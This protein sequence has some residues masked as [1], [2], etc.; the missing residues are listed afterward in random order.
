MVKLCII[1]LLI[2]STLLPVVKAQVVINEIQSSN[3]SG[4]VDEDNEHSDWIELYNSSDTAENIE[5]YILN[6]KRT[7]SSGWV[8]PPVNILPN[9]YLLVFASGKDRNVVTPKY[10]TIIKRGDTWKYFVATSG[11]PKNWRDPDFNDSLWVSGPSGF[12]FGDNDDST[13]INNAQTVL[14]RKEFEIEDTSSISEML[15]H[16]DYDDG[17]IA[18]INGIEVAMGN[19]TSFNKDFSVVQTGSREALMCSGGDPE[20]FTISSLISTLRNGRNVIAIQGHNSSAN[21]SDFSLI[22]FLTLGSTDYTANDAEHFVNIRNGYLHTNFKIS[23]DGEA[24]YLFNASSERIDSTKSIALGDDISYGRFIDGD[25]AWYYFEQPTPGS[26]N[27]NP[28][29][30]IIRDS[31]FF[32]EKAGFYSQPFGLVMYATSDSG[33]IYFTTDGSVPT[34]ESQIYTD[35][36]TISATTVIRAAFF[37]DSLSKN[38]VTTETFIFNTSNG[39]PVVSISSDPKNFFDWN[40]GILVM[41]PNA[42][43]ANPN[44][45]ANFWMDW[46]K[47]IN[48]EYFDKDGVPHI[49]QGAGIKVSGMWSR[50]NAQKSVAIFARKEYGKGAFK[51]K[52]F[53]DRVN[54]TFES[55]TLRNSG[56]DWSYTMMRDGLFSEMAKDMDIDREAYQPSVVYLNGEYWGI[57]N[58]RERASEHY[59]SENFGVDDKEVNILEN[60]GNVVYGKNEDYV[61]LRSFINTKS[62]LSTENY[63]QVIEKMD[64][65]CF[66]DYELFQIYIDNGDWPGN[67]IKYWKSNDLISKWR[68]ILY[69]ADFGF[70]IYGGPYERNTLIFATTDNHNE[71]PN[72]PWS[73]LFLRKLL[74]NEEFKNQ[75]VNRFSDC[76]NS[77]L[78]A[79]N[80]ISKI[81]SIQNIIYPEIENHIT[82]WS[83]S[84]EWWNYSVEFLRSFARN[85]KVNMRKYMKS[86]FG[87]KLDNIITLYISDSKAGKIKINSITPVIYPFSGNYFGEV[88]ILLKAIP[89]PGYRFVRWE[90]D[91][92]S[93]NGSIEVN[94]TSNKK[95]NAVFEPS[96]GTDYQAVINEI[97]YYPGEEFDAGDWIEIYNNG[98]QT[99]DLTNWIIQDADTSNRFIFPAGQLL[100]PQDYLVLT[101]SNLKFH[102]VYP[103]ITNR[104]GDFKFGLSNNGD[105]IYLF[106]NEGALI[107]KVNYGVKEPWPVKAFG[108][109]ATL[110]LKDP[111]LNND[112]AGNWDAAKIGGTPGSRNSVVVSASVLANAGHQATCFPTNFTDYTTLRFYTPSDGDYTVQ[113]IDMQ[114]RVLE[115]HQGSFHSQGINYLDIFTEKENYRS[116]IYFV[117]LQT[118][119]GVQTVKVIKE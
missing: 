54:E 89:N 108:T 67:N 61:K 69:D 53:N 44:F 70:D 105:I 21:S 80:V 35:T 43:A 8:F 47:P 51:Y 82:R 101:G 42:E 9:N 52:F 88:P 19:I 72:P 115:K 94:L 45:G 12:G 71:W 15:L 86:F 78:L 98:N 28:V 99:V 36:L 33:N 4:I 17:F 62:L 77:N 117:K 38:P 56:N 104:V 114:G 111:S 34:I 66:I 13:I 32:N 26:K 39:L 57:L 23:K 18:F 14:I 29:G 110:E 60:D 90:D 58:I 76:L 74:A 40:E 55:I 16:V 11:M 97:N 59:L 49:N 6:D 100:Y 107:D 79:A 83:S 63:Q 103:N 31:V 41:G 50:A 81:D 102:S 113:I 92:N 93:T 84:N 30:E 48:F 46:E 27:I 20:L 3:V 65:G 85:R 118:S 109:G 2:L 37:I 75:F 95:F 73:T 22:P 5:G 106:D 24:I 1:F 119:N 96:I 7:D 10:H 91:S 68:W 112:L 25:T 116:G 87:F 64:I